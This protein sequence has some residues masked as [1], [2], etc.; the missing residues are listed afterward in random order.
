M[1]L[2]IKWAL[3]SPLT[4]EPGSILQLVSYF[5]LWLQQLKNAKYIRQNLW[6]YQGHLQKGNIHKPRSIEMYRTSKP[7]ARTRQ[8]LC[9]VGSIRVL[10]LLRIITRQQG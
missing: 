9:C 4:A 1:L 7:P 5:D 10:E 6:M 8:L 3:L 2:N